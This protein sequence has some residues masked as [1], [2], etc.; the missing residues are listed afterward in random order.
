MTNNAIELAEAAGFARALAQGAGDLILSHYRS[1][2]VELKPDGSEVTAADREAEEFIRKQLESYT[3]QAA[4]LG[5]EYGGEAKPQPGD[6]WIVDPLDGTTPFALGLPLFGTLIA[7]LRDGEPVLGVIHM[8][9]MDETVYA[10]AGG[11]CWFVV[12]NDEPQRVRTESVGGLEEAFISAAG[13]H[14]SELE[15]IAEHA[16]YRLAPLIEA[17]RKFRV[18]G[19]CVQHALV[20]RGRLHLAIDSIMAPWDSAALIPC[21]RE[22]GGAVSD[23]QGQSQDLTFAGSLV[24]ASDQGVLDEALVLMAPV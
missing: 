17:T 18:V 21:V 15:P 11:G 16:S 4:I 13:V 9:A 6:H 24:S 14:A 10:W 1:V 8:P 22:A 5:E 2:A 12:G 3:P 7:L 19:D 20:C 23:L